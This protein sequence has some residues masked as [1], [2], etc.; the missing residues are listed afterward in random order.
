MYT[1]EEQAQERHGDLIA[2][3]LLHGEIAGL[4]LRALHS[5][6]FDR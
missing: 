3:F 4:P 6:Q 1:A 2:V 5:R